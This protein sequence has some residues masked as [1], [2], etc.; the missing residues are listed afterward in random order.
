MSLHRP[1]KPFS[2]HTSRS[3]MR[4]M[5]DQQENWRKYLFF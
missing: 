1:P 3:L 5:G 4:Q 2:L